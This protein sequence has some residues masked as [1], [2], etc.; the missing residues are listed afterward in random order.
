[1]NERPLSPAGSTDRRNT[2]SEPLCWCLE[3]QGLS[4]PLIELAGDRAQLG[5]GM[6]RQISSTG[7]ILPEQPV[8][9]FV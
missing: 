8:G 6:D 9:V 1:M 5:L 7:Q 4:R 2:L 3:F